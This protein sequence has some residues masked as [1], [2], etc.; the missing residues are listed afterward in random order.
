M[1]TIGFLAVTVP[2]MIAIGLDGYALG[3]AIVL[4]FDLASRAYYLARLFPGFNLLTHGL[5]LSH[6]ACPLWLP[7]SRFRV[8]ADAERSLAYVLA[9]LAIY[10]VFNLLFAWRFERHAADRDVRLPAR[11]AAPGMNALSPRRG[12]DPA[13]EEAELR[14]YL[15]PAF[16]RSRL[17]RYEHQLDEEFAACGD[18]AA[19]TDAPRPTSTT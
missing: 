16:D 15:G 6:R 11:R 12:F 5:A 10:V 14:E 19:C 9:E 1:I 18:E 17:Q 8:A 4:L 3:M 2:L 7:C 13:R